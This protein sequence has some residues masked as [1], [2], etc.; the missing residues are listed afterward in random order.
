M[1]YR[2]IFKLSILMFVLEIAAQS[3]LPQQFNSKIKDIMTLIYGSVG[4][5]AT[6]LEHNKIELLLH[7]L[8]AASSCQLYTIAHLVIKELQEEKQKTVE[9]IEQKNEENEVVSQKQFFARFS[10]DEQIKYLEN[11]RKKVYENFSILEWLQCIFEQHFNKLLGW[12]KLSFKEESP[13]W[14]ESVADRIV[15]YIHFEREHILFD[16][17]NLLT[18]F[19][20]IKKNPLPTIINFWSDKNLQQKLALRARTITPEVKV[21]FLEEIFMMALQAYIMA[22]GSMYIQW[23]DQADAD[24]F[25]EL[26][27]KQNDIQSQFE[28]FMKQLNASQKIVT[29]KIITAFKTSMKDLSEDYKKVNEQQQKEQVY[30]FKSINLDYPIQHALTLPPVPYDQVFQAGIMNTPQKH[31]WYNIYQ[32]GDWEFDVQ[33][34]SFW[35]N[36]LISFGTP[37]WLATEKTDQTTIS[38]PSQN[39]IFTEYISNDASYNI[40][41]EC[42]LMNCKYPFFVGVMFNRARWIS[43][44]PERIWQYRL[45]G[46]YG[47]QTKME[48]PTTRSINFAF[49]QQIIT[50]ED[51]K[52]KII[53]P[54]EQITRATTFAYALPKADVDLLVK[55][56]ITF[57][58][59]ITIN[60]VGGIPSQVA[61]KHLGMIIC[62]NR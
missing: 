47:T 30:L 37:F 27:K 52:E 41:V 58:F 59:D 39:N 16:Y 62:L 54:L 8:Y 57:V 34:N 44:D 7:D 18:F 19:I 42:T 29:S 46:L 61:L 60:T 56:S 20:G 12:L 32:Y 50:T 21:Q 43:G 13:S 35:Q 22:G 55:D 40:V 53:S 33:N 2:I 36:G 5:H 15:D 17:T 38:D 48:D 45:C 31:T 28:E 3:N 9:Q 14:E 11:Y 24:A 25:A 51:N 23:L 26:T 10:L 1:N 6:P 49:A 4:I